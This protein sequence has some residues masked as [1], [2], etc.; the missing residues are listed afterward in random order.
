MVD[1]TG[2]KEE[3]DGGETLKELLYRYSI[4]KKGKHANYWHLI[5]VGG[6]THNSY[7]C[8]FIFFNIYVYLKYIIIIIFPI[9][10]DS[11]IKILKDFIVW[12]QINWLQFKFP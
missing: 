7:S 1:A 3:R 4:K 11:V 8:L 2:W 9:L 12:N 6:G 5:H 10:R